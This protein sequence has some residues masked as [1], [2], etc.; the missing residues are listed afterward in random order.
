MLIN[1]NFGY[2]IVDKRAADFPDKIAVKALTDNDFV[3]EISNADLHHHSDVA[4]YYLQRMGVKPASRVLLCGLE[5]HFEFAII[6][7]ALHK[8]CAVPVFDFTQNAV[9]CANSV[10]VY[11]II[12][13][14]NSADVEHITQNISKLKTA[15]ILISV[16]NPCPDY[17]LDLHTGMRFAKQF[18]PLK[19]V[20]ANYDSMIIFDKKPQ[21]FNQNYPL[22]T[23]TDF[24]WDK[25]YRA[26]INN[27]IWCC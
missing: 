5:K 14:N 16:G 4:A 17:W 1:F 24:A 7:T 8:L 15:E 27:E 10:A 26:M 22:E 2:D 25:F 6:L 9:N 19:N 12:A 3:L 13:A 20:P 23:K 18:Q 11:A 21:F